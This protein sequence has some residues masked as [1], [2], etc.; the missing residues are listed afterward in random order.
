MSEAQELSGSVWLNG[1]VV[2]AARARVSALDRG[3][4][5]GDGLFETVRCYRGVPFLLD[6]HIGRMARSAEFLAL[7]LPEV[8]WL[9]AVRKL[10]A[11]NH[12]LEA[13]ASVRITVTRGAAPPGLVPPRSPRP[14]VMA[15]A[16]PLP[17]TLTREQRLGVRV[18]TVPLYRC[19]PLAA[20][21]LLD[22]VPAILARAAAAKRKAR[23]ALYVHDGMVCEATTA[24]V[25]AVF[26]NTLVT[27]PLNE[28]LPGITREFVLSLAQS[29]GIQTI[30][31]AIRIE[32]LHRADELFLTSAVL[33][34]LP[35]TRVDELTIGTG[36][37]GPITRQLQQ[38]YRQRVNQL[39]GARKRK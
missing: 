14:T 28:L 39:C 31:R 4:L 17:R 6:G 29:A 32:E 33:E 26:G 30:E 9:S 16:L 25:F 38:A 22:Y 2:P 24:N 35:V 19:G 7:P 18:I 36:V 1:R 15:F 12:L 34:V 8:D 11:A 20:H 13:D 21:K 10:L 5:Y 23:E 3:F 37:P 27:P